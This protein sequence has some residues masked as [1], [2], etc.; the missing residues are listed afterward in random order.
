M[1]SQSYFGSD[2]MIQ[3]LLAGGLDRARYDVHVAVD[4]GPEPGGT[5]AYRAICSLPATTVVPTNFGPTIYQRSRGD[6]ARGL[7]RGLGAIRSLPELAIYAR[8]KRIRII[9]GTEKPRDSLLGANIARLIGAR[10]VLHLHVKCHEDLNAR[11]RLAL[12]QAHLVLGVS[13]FV[14]ESVVQAG[15]PREKVDYIVN[16]IDA[17]GWDPETDGTKIRR[18]FGLSPD[19]P[20]AVIAARIF[21]WK[22]H[23]ELIRAMASVRESFPT[24]KLI[25][26]GEDEP[27]AHGGKSFTAEL[28]T[29]LA[30]LGLEE[31]VIFTG[32]RSDV[33]EFLAAADVYAMPT[34]EEPCAV[35]FLEAMAMKKATVALR[36]GGTPEMIQEGLSGFLSEPGDIPAL[37]ENIK[38]LFAD[39]ALRQRFGEHARERVLSHHTPERMCQDLDR[40]YSRLLGRRPA[41]TLDASAA[42]A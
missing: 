42:T 36:S 39:S 27:R 20:L 6:I 19:Q 9:H 12:K 40:V 22:G 24:A 5:A 15:F 34:F 7:G 10:S 21:K 29:L 30:E 2:S 18:E 16:G 8:R 28:R 37:A 3:S 31:Q 26:V 33:R 23:Q 14:A 17:S 13:S 11:Q 4:P 25:I 41:A 38:R 35:A 32:F 1:Q